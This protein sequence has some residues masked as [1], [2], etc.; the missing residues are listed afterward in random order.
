MGSARQ[1]AAA[2]A[3]E[4]GW[5]AAGIEGVGLTYGADG[6]AA[7]AEPVGDAVPF[8]D[9]PPGPFHSPGTPGMVVPRGALAGT[10]YSGCASTADATGTGNGPLSLAAEGVG[11]VTAGAGAAG[12]FT[13]AFGLCAGSGV[14]AKSP[15]TH[16][17]A[18]VHT[19]LYQ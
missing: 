19:S 14:F 9:E 3:G 13:G 17:E 16:A 5:D 12:C 6:G 7:P 10:A 2:E 4:T 8:V 11:T 18:R 1:K 15:A